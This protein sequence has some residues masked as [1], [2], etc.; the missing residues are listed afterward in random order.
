MGD[1]IDALVRETLFSVRMTPRE[2]RAKVNAI[3]ERARAKQGFVPRVVRSYNLP[4]RGNVVYFVQ[5]P[6][7]TPIKIGT[8]IDLS[9]RL[10]GLQNGNGFDVHVLGW[11]PGGR[12]EEQ[13]IHRLFADDR[14][15]GEWFRPSKALVS[16]IEENAEKP[17]GR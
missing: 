4:R 2:F 1:W 15:H 3:D 8:T 6:P 5:G 16:F 14:K 17:L 10:C 13:R 9:L 7:K 11:I 12:D